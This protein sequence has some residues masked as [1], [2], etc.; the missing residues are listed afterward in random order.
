MNEELEWA[1][2]REILAML[3]N[4]S[5]G[6]KKRNLSGRD[7]IPL[8]IDGDASEVDEQEAIDQFLA[9]AKK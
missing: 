8:G 1:R 5:M 6:A 7:L 9:L 4:T 3:S 2:T